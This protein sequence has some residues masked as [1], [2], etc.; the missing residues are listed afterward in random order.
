MREKAIPVELRPPDSVTVTDADFTVTLSYPNAEEQGAAYDAIVAALKAAP[1]PI[2]SDEE[3]AE[4]WRADP[5]LA[6]GPEDPA[7]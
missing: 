7:P 5:P 1:E 6:G 3:L 4:A 2:P